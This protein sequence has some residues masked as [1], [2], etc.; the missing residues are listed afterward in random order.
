MEDWQEGASAADVQASGQFGKPSGRTGAS[1]PSRLNGQAKGIGG[2]KLYTGDYQ[3][4]NA[5][6][7][8]GKVRVR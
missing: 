4:T 8:Y 1:P 6:G 2:G 7:P 5:R 3:T